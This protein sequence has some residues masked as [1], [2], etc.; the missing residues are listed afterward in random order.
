MEPTV[1]EKNFKKAR[2]IALAMMASVLVYIGLAEFFLGD[3]LN[4][5]F[6][7]LDLFR[8]AVYIISG[9]ETGVIVWVR[10]MLLKKTTPLPPMGTN[11]LKQ[12]E[13]TMNGGPTDKGNITVSQR[14]LTTTIIVFALCESIAIYG[15][16]LFI[17]GG[18]RQDLYLLAG[19][20][21]IL[22]YIFFP[23]FEDW[24][25]RSNESRRNGQNHPH[26][27]R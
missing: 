13:Q 15:L 23:R 25:S 9:I 21:L 27:I 7:R 17:L 16:V 26:H 4:V 22:M 10:N 2:V 11:R 20:A 24:K 3:Y 8:I 19:L 12:G 18:Q 1:L 6:P 5:S 14:L